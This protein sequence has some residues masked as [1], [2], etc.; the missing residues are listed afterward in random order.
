MYS[1]ACFSAKFKQQRVRCAAQPSGGREMPS[2][3]FHH[4]KCISDYRPS[5]GGHCSGCGKDL[6]RTARAS[7]IDEAHIRSLIG[8]G[9]TVGAIKYVRERFRVSLADSKLIIHH[10]HGAG[11]RAPGPP[12][13]KCGTPLRTLRARMCVECGSRRGSDASL[14]PNISLER[15]RER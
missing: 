5:K 11:V 6:P 10:M 7:S 2:Q 15:T 1:R 8:S 12:C 14:P 13:E 3:A 4:S 9:H